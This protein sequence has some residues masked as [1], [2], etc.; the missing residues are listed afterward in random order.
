MG[1]ASSGHDS[2]TSRM[3]IVCIVLFKKRRARHPTSATTQT[4]FNEAQAAWRKAR[5]EFDKAVRACRIKCYQ[6]LVASLDDGR[7]KLLWSAW[8]RVS[9]TPRIPMAS[10]HDPNTEQ[11][12]LSQQHA[13]N[14]MADFLKR[15]STSTQTTTNDPAEQQMQEEHV[16]QYLLNIDPESDISAEPPFTLDDVIKLCET[17][18]TNTALGSDNISPHF[19]RRGGELL[20]KSVF[21]LLS[22]CSRHGLIPQQLRHARYD[23]IQGGKGTPMIRTVTGP[24]QSHPSLHECMNDY[25]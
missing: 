17:S 2:H 11:P 10:V 15:I 21:M 1:S 14:N 13:I 9:G 8:R 19:L 18:R 12:P 3:H 5:S 4:R 6:E 7:H 16:R 20:H 22:I 23:S 25:T 24:S